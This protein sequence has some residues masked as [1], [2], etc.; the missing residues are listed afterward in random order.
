MYFSKMFL[1]TLREVP[2]EAEIMSHK[3][4]LRA[5]LIAIGIGHISFLP[6]ICVR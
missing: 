2:A 3:W 1:P 4:M 5:G 6:L